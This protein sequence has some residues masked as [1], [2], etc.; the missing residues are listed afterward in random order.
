LGDRVEFIDDLDRRDQTILAPAFPVFIKRLLALPLKDLLMPLLPFRP[1]AR[2]TLAPLDRAQHV[3]EHGLDVAD[4]WHIYPHI[5]GNRRR[6]DVEMND[7][8]GLGRE[9]R[10]TS[11]N[12]VVEACADADQTIGM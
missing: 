11:G 5:L 2:D 6:I 7:G 10:D 9:I 8:F 3:L 12:P 4:N 1:P